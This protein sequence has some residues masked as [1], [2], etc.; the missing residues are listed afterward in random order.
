M[1]S[2]NQ[3]SRQSHA[4]FRRAIRGSFSLTGKVDRDGTS[5]WWKAAVMSP[6]TQ[7]AQE[8]R[9]CRENW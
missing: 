7:Q 2:V 6:D 1:P 8:L 4:L 9:L 5:Y 3:S